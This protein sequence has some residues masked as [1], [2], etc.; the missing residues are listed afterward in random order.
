METTE[1]IDGTPVLVDYCRR[2][3]GRGYIPRYGNVSKG[4]C[5]DC[6]WTGKR[7]LSATAHARVFRSLERFAAV[8]AQSPRTARRHPGSACRLAGRLRDDA[9]DR[10]RRP[11]ARLRRLGA[12]RMTPYGRDLARHTPTRRERGE[13][14]E[15]CVC[16]HARNEQL[17]PLPRLPRP[18]L[19][20]RDHQSLPLRL[21]HGRRV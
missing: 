8:Q 7:I 12:N 20:V 13:G 2:C 14:F 19:A 6:W 1:R 9:Q 5:F 18:R 4:A 11:P 3:S 16:G 15:L 17:R 21:V 10:R